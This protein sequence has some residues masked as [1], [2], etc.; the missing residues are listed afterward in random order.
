MQTGLDATSG[1]IVVFLDG[2]VENFAP[3]FVTGLLGPVFARPETVL[4]KGCYRRP[5]DGAATGGGRVTEL[6]ARPVLSLLFPELAGVVQPLAGEV[7]VR[8]GALEGIE[9]AAGYGVE[10]AMLIDLARRFGAGSIAQVDLDVR[11]HRNRPLHELAPQARA[12]LA[13]ALLRA[14]VAIRRARLRA[15][16]ASSWRRTGGRTR[17][18]VGPTAR[19]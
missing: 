19:R 3:H 9:L 2:D 12:V 18:I 8:R 7:A 17:S 10:I 1:E 16:S 14:G 11:V 4:V 5:I 13:E 15:R 6:A